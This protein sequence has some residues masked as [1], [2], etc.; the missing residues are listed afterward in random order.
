[1]PQGRS[2]FSR[3]LPIALLV[4]S[5]PLACA[6]GVQPEVDD[7][8]DPGMAG[9]TAAPGGA[10]GSSA[11]ASGTMPKAGTTATN[12]GGGAEPFGGTGSTGGKGNA[13]SGAGGGGS[14]SGGAGGGATAGAGGSSSAGAGGSGGACA[15]GATLMWKDNAS[16]NWVTG[17]CMTVSGKTYRYTGTKAQTY[18]HGDCNPTKQEAWCTDVGNDYKFVACP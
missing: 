5:L 4:V 8:T 11:G 16:M 17:D 18:A 6:V 2:I 3:R 9:T 10:G 1:M 15:C 13:T 12:A 7:A 14:S